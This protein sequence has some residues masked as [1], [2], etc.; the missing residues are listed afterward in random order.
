[1]KKTAILIML[2]TALILT[3]CGS[4]YKKGVQA[5]EDKNYSDA[6]SEL[7]QVEESDEN[8]GDAQLILRKSQF[9]LLVANFKSGMDQNDRIKSIK[10]MT[11]LA[12]L[13]NTKEVA[14]ET[15]NTLLAQ[16]K[17]AK[18]PAYV[19]ELLNQLI[20]MVKEKGDMS[21][22]SGL[23]KELFG[24]VK[25]FIFDSDMRSAFKNSIKEL[26]NLGN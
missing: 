19:K 20:Q 15:F 17:E 25:E 2:I 4:H 14:E 3:S 18:D 8:Y 6:V 22:V 24:K 16:L 13:I 21:R 12:L 23:I 5:Y 11:S 7:K 9:G 26:K 10:E 1:M